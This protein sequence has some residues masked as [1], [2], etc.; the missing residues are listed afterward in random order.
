MRSID[1]DLVQPEEAL[2]RLFQMRLAEPSMDSR[3]G[4]EACTDATSGGAMVVAL[5]RSD[6]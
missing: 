6:K 5:P 2:H 3:D 1:G 4:A